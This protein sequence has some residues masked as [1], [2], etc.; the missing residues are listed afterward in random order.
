M[1]GIRDLLSSFGDHNH[2][3]WGRCNAIVSFKMF[4]P[5]KPFN[6]LERGKK[7]KAEKKAA[8]QKQ[9]FARLKRNA[10]RMLLTGGLGEE[11][12]G[13]DGG[14]I[15]VFCRAAYERFAIGAETHFLSALLAFDAS[16][17]ADHDQI[18]F[19]GVEITVVGA[20]GDHH[21][22]MLFYLHLIAEL[23]EDAHLS[24]QNDE[25]VVLVDM[26]M[27]FIFSALGVDFG[28]NPQVRRFGDELGDSSLFHVRRF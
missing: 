3:K 28:V 2:K 24:F 25:G 18:A 17:D 7:T 22:L 14:E 11:L 1:I 13:F 8:R 6:S 4:K 23:I 27:N 12:A 15:A 5:F 9:L 20:L 26:F 19:A 21:A 10:D 16:A